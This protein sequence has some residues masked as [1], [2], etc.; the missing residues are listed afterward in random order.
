MGFD[1]MLGETLG[2]FRAGG[3]FADR[4]KK[5]FPSA[6]VETIFGAVKYYFAESSDGAELFRFNFAK[7]KLKETRLNLEAD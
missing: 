6:L 2:D 7:D 4:N 5:A 3:G 1:G